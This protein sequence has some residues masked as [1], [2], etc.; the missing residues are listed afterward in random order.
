M[1]LRIAKKNIIVFQNGLNR[2][3]H[4]LIRELATEFEGKLNI[5][6]SVPLE[7]KFQEL[8]KEEKKL[9]ISYK[10]KFNESAKF[11]LCLLSN[12]VTSLVEEIH[13]IKRKYGPG[14]RKMR[15][16]WN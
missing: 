2:F 16:I 6:F 14:N 9:I 1:K 11:M 13:K 5:T 8:I 10:I 12:L 15:R 3:C 7:K 4:L